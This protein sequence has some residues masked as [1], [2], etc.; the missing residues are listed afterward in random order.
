MPGHGPPL[1]RV[2]SYHGVKEQTV[3]GAFPAVFRT[4]AKVQMA[5]PKHRFLIRLT[6]QLYYSITNVDGSILGPYITAI[7]YSQH[8]FDVFMQKLRNFFMIC[9]VINLGYALN[10]HSS[11]VMCAIL[12]EMVLSK[13]EVF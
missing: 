7:S 6:L 13:R 3:V 4:R 1:I 2:N 5:L 10:I 12:Q 8:A 11:I 9:S